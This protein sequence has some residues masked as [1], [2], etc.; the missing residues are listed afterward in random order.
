MPYEK[1]LCVLKQLKKG[2]SADGSPLS[3]AAYAER[4]GQELI[5]SPKIVGLSPLREG[6]YALA[7][8]I[9]GKTY[10]LELK[11][12]E[13]LR[14]PDTP[15]LKDGFSALL[16]FVRSGDAEPIAYGYCGGAPSEHGILL[17]VFSKKERMPEE[18]KK[19]Q[20]SELKSKAEPPVPSKPEHGEAASE[21]DP[22]RGIAAADG[23]PAFGS[24]KYDDE[25]IASS[26]YFGGIWATL[27]DAGADACGKDEEKAAKDGD[28]SCEDETNQTV[29]PFRLARGGLTYYKE[30]AP[31]LAAAMKKY[32][33]DDTLKSV[34]PSSEWVKVEKALLGVIYA[35][36]LP[37][38]L[39]VAMKDEPPKEVKEFCIAVPESPYTETERYFV[40]FQDADTGEY[41][42]V[43]NT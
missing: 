10:C 17:S 20:K 9:G 8:W 19:P 15:P 43:E 33:K 31:R 28:R 34:F 25:A 12:N 37:R 29:H 13:Q 40:V 16:C 7:L 4:L 11:G 36:G 39:C 42:R 32:P 22:F 18:R 23:K 35:E 26:D 1:R 27:E 24:G 14:I 41:V 30:V 21:Q 6:R 3:G 5:L 38:Y 2:F